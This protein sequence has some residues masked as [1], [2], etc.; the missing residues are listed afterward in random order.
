MKA[1]KKPVNMGNCTKIEVVQR[2]DDKP[3][4]RFQ[5]VSHW[6]G[7]DVTHVSGFGETEKKARLDHG[8]NIQRLKKEGMQQ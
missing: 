2:P 5:I 4:Y 6:K 1:N 3:Q 8:H 7:G